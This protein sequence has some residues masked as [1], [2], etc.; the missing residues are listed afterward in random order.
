[1][2]RSAK[3]R[4]FF[5][6]QLT[7]PWWPVCG[8]ITRKPQDADKDNEGEV[9]E[10]IPIAGNFQ[11]STGKLLDPKY[12][13]LQDLPDSQSEGL[14]I[15]LHGG[16]YNNKEQQAIIDMQCDPERTGNERK[17]FRKTP[18]GG[19][20]KDD[21]D[22][23][24]EDDDDDGDDLNSLTFVSYG[25]ENP[26]QEVQ[27]LRLDWRTKYACDSF[28]RDDDGDDGDDD[29]GR[30]DEGGEGKEANKSRHWGFFT[31]LILMY[32]C[33]FGPSLVRPSCGPLLVPSSS[34]IF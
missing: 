29:E 26:D 6:L 22:D 13:R 31:W 24:D 15:E 10:V 19:D 34:Y 16:T 1:M 5:L 9:D 3:K 7:S 20:D 23:D 2:Q 32:V 11:L 21:D 14:R 33:S 18:K 12:K 28:E 4:H 25:F 30:D 17:P 27:T 8:I